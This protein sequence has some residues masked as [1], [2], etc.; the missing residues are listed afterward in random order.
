MSNGQSPILFIFKSFYIYQPEEQPIVPPLL[1]TGLKTSARLVV[2]MLN[3]HGIYAVLAEAK[4]QNSIQDLVTKYDA[5]RVILEAIWVTPQKMQELADANLT[6]YWTVRVHSEIP[7]LA[8]EGMSLTWLSAYSK[9]GIEIA[10]NSMQTVEDYSI[11]GNSVY[12]PNYYPPRQPRELTRWSDVLNIG[13]FGSIRP[14][15]NQ[16][17]QAFAALRYARWRNMPLVFHMNGVRVEQSGAN[18]LK[19]IKA[20]FAETNQT[21]ALHPWMGHKE[22]LALVSR[23][24]ICLCVSLSESFCIVAADAVSM[25]VP[26]VASRAISWMPSSSHAQVDSVA[27]IVY[28]MQRV[29]RSTIKHNT[30]ALHAFAT[31]SVSAWKTW[32]EFP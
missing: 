3:A 18:N 13:C 26:V 29:S 10:F 21:L 4:D 32:V 12:L 23:M 20:L 24:D 6:V 8:N 2:D 5:K 9:L 17:I 16:L 27:S 1:S 25:G 7:F 14:M 11:V 22:F 30:K 19:N 28:A 15:K 31:K